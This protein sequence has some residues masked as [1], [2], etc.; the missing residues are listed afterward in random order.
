MAVRVDTRAARDPRPLAPAALQALF[1]LGLLAALV[2][3]YAG[4]DHFE[5]TGDVVTSIGRT[6]GLLAVYLCLVL[7]VLMARIPWLERAAG[8]DRLTAWHRAVG[9]STVLLVAVHGAVVVGGYAID[10]HRSYPGEAWH[11][12]ST[13]PGMVRGLIAGGLLVLI[14]ITSARAVRRRLRYEVWW[15]I[16]LA[17]YAAVVLAFAHQAAA[18]DQFVGDATAVD[19]LRAI[20]LAVLAAALWWRVVVPL[21]NAFA[22]RLTVDDVRPE[23][24]GAASI[25]IRGD[26]LRALGARPGQFLLLRFLT[27][28][29]WTSAHPYSL[30]SPPEGDAIRI[31][32]RDDG[33]HSAATLR[34][35]CGCRVIA[36]GPFGRF[37]ADAGRPDAPALL[38]GGGSGIV[39][40]RAIASALGTAG[41]D[42]VVVQRARTADG[43]LLGDELRGAAAAGQLTLHQIA[44]RRE[45]LGAD[46]LAPDALAALVPD[47]GAR[48]VWV[49]GPAAMIATAVASCRALG[50][51]A[52]RLHVE[53][54]AW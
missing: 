39:P 4:A 50:V 37:T 36:E 46:P 48:D 19:V 16:H 21:R 6:A 53:E 24:P 40:L 41:R 5:G 44:G 1:G 7:V 30:S 2:P 47:A 22:H 34:V 43:L 45:E 49:C 33:D 35:R 28:G 11:V 14:G 51:P 13:Y 17:A 20:Y 9:A 42:V 23:G 29:L 38:I 3:W 15:L 52:R 54:F 8:F 26:A 32:V 10:D 25:V 27:R 12:A 18:G 31:T